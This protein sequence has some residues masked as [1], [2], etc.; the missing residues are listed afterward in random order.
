MPIELL[1][2]VIL[3]TYRLTLLMSKEAGPFDIFGRFR[4]WVGVEYDEHSRPY[5]SNQFAEMVMCPYCLSVW[6]GLGVTILTVAAHV[7]GVEKILFYVLLPLALSGLSVF[8]F[9]WTGV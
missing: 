6:M 9:K 5:G 8:L 2:V 4:T 3:T 7:L 1:I